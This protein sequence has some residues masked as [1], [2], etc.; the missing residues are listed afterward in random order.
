MSGGI[1]IRANIYN[2]MVVNSLNLTFV[3][4]SDPTRRS[5]LNLLREGPATVNQL[6]EPFG[7]SQ[8]AISKHL[9]YLERAKLIEKR[10]EGRQQFCSLNPISLKEAC[11]WMER[12]REFWEEAFDRMDVLLQDLKQQKQKEKKNV[13]RKQ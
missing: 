13:G 2:Y 4:L 12:Y 6:A 7:I 9:A 5:I 8:Q 10:K 11:D 3:A 1:D